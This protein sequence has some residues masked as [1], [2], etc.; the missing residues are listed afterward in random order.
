MT[1]PS[2]QRKAGPLLGTGVQTAWPFTFKI[3]AEGDIKVTTADSL[4]TETELVLNTDYSV[5]VNANQDT[6]P[7][8]TVTYPLSGSPLAIGSK[9]TITGDLDYDQPLDLPAGGNFSPQAIENELDRIVMQVQQLREQLGRALLAPVTSDASGQLPAPQSNTLIG[10]DVNGALQNVPLSDLATAA[11]Y[12]TW[13]WD[14]FTGDG[15]TLTFALTDDPI[16]IA[17]LAVTIDG[18]TLTPGVDFTLTSGSLVFPSAPSN[19]AEILARYGEALVSEV[20][21][22]LSTG[23]TD[24]TAIGRAVLTAASTADARTAIGA[25]ASL[26]YTPVNRAGDTM[27]GALVLHADPAAA[28]GAATKQYVD[29]MAL[30]T[31]TGNSGKVLK[32]NGSAASWDSVDT[33]GTVV[34]TTSG[35]AHDVTGIPN[36]VNEV[37]ISF[38]KVSTNGTSPVRLQLGSGGAVQ[39]TGYESTATVM[40]V[41]NGTSTGGFDRYQTAAADVTSGWFILIRI[42]GNTWLCIAQYAL[43]T[44]SNPGWITGNVT[45]SG[46]LDRIRFTTVGGTDAFD[47]GNFNT[48]LR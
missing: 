42:T 44:A 25:Q 41:A 10:W 17:N 22:I 13:H 16:V 18:L 32:T 31:Q 46:A 33:V 47:G 19:G 21:T 40:G 34:N 8:G 37:I 38:S 11:T 27:T 29:A 14:S 20:G 5:S 30:P 4:G 23:I 15:A 45:L 35:T 36:W 9:L 24:S 6:S 7:G 1:T 39:T 12:G 28:L 2:T 43:N 26:G 48:I 3:F